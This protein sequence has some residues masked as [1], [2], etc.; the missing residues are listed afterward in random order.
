MISSCAPTAETADRSVYKILRKCLS[1]GRL[2]ISSDK[3]QVVRF[4]RFWDSQLSL[5]GLSPLKPQLYIQDSYSL[6]G[7]QRVLGEL[8]WLRP[9]SLF[10]QVNS[11]PLDLLKDRQPNDEITLYLPTK[12]SFKTFKGP[13]MGPA[14]CQVYSWRESTIVGPACL[15]L[16]IHPWSRGKASTVG[17]HLFGGTPESIPV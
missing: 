2:H 12:R 15:S 9:W 16:L 7:L 1:K 6:T 8:N 10:Q 14:F 17:S 4:L 11:C 5:E 3:V 13:L